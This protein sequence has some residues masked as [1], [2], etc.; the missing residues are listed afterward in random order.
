MDVVPLTF[1]FLFEYVLFFIGSGSTVTGVSDT[2]GGGSASTDVVPLTFSLL[3]FFSHFL[4]FFSMTLRE[5]LIFLHRFYL[6]LT[7][8]ILPHN[9]LT[10]DLL[11]YF[12][13][14]LQFTA[15]FEQYLLSNILVCCFTVTIYSSLFFRNVLVTDRQKAELREFFRMH[16]MLYIYHFFNADLHEFFHVPLLDPLLEPAN[17]FDRRRG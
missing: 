16:D 13:T 3:Q 7:C 11:L 10:M 9:S 14:A 1:E 6:C 17:I 5:L 8:R 2:K 12:G 15:F 4:L